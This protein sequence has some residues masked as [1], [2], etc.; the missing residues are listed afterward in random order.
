[1]RSLTDT[2]INRNYLPCL[3]HNS[4]LLI[5]HLAFTTR[6]LLI[7]PKPYSTLFNYMLVEAGLKWST[8]LCRCTLQLSHRSL[9]PT[10]SCLLLQVWTPKPCTLISRPPFLE[11]LPSRVSEQTRAKTL[12][13]SH[14]DTASA[15]NE[16]L[17]RGLPHA[18]LHRE[19]AAATT[20]KGCL[21]GR[22]QKVAPASDV[23]SR[24]ALDGGPA[25]PPDRE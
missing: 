25:A 14:G 8:Q 7:N 10:N 1:M 18:H 23:Q 19:T 11:C 12:T 22:T 15:G 20:S 9:L 17:Q 3:L 21:N 4:C 16:R 13:P 2:R 6:F 24:A 5:F